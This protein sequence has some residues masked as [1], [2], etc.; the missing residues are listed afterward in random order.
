M[1]ARNKPLLVAQYD[2]PVERRIGYEEGEE[3]SILAL[4]VEPFRVNL[5]EARAIQ[6]LRDSCKRILD[7]T[8]DRRSECNGGHRLI[9]SPC[10]IIKEAEI[11]VA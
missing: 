4:L 5:R 2:M 7:E 3:R 10:Q 8:P 1:P 6:R 11:T 9:L